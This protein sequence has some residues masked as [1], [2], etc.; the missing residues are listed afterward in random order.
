MCIFICMLS[1]KRTLDSWRCGSMVKPSPSALVCY[2]WRLHSS[3]SAGMERGMET[4]IKNKGK[5]SKWEK[6][7]ELN[8]QPMS[9]NTGYLQH[10]CKMLFPMFEAQWLFTQAWGKA[11]THIYLNILSSFV[12]SVALVILLLFLTSAF[13]RFCSDKSVSRFKQ[14]IVMWSN[15]SLCLHLNV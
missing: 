3:S 11:G 12:S 15:S 2:M 8:L 14:S 4:N 5:Q 7:W 9:V 13:I 6:G 10:I 1:Q